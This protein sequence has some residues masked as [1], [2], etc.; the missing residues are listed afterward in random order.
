MRR[1]FALVAAVILLDTMFYAAIAPLLPTYADDLGLSKTAAGILSASYAAGTLLAS[2]PA[3]F[4][5]A[6]VGVR[7]TMLTGLGLIAVSSVAFAF[8]NEIVVLDLARFAEGVGGAFAWTAGLTWILA[9]A[10]RERRGQM[11]GS[12]LAVAIFGIMLGPVLG[13]VA[14][15]LGPEAVFSAVGAGAAALACW[16]AVTP[17]ARLEGRDSPAKVL[18]VIATAPVL[19][20]FWLVVLPSMLSGLFDVLVPLRLDE[21]GASG[22]AVGAVFLVA[23]AIEAGT[24]PRV[25]AFSDRRGA[26]TPIR[27]GLVAGAVAALVMPL[28]GTIVLVA[29]ALVA[30]VLALSLIWTPAM[31]MLSDA[32]ENAG[33]NLAFAAA[34]TNLA[35]SGG[36]VIGGSAGPALADAASDATAYAVVAG[37]FALTF[38]TFA[39]RRRAA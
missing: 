8:A 24:A 20:A 36:Q 29:V 10:P 32:A 26:M 19:V 11:I 3:G 5:A 33:L 25:G 23:A 12:V 6:R 39:A 4:F 1:L 16:A 14:T 2:I 35:W 22:V 18:A 34:L 21:L 9:T 13:A 27:F 28:P 15:V 37:L 30:V 17:P 7:V 31:A 38:L